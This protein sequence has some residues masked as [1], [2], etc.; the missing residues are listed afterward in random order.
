M[1]RKSIVVQ[2]LVLAMLAALYFMNAGLAVAG[3]NTE[4]LCHV[5]D[6]DPHTILVN[7]N[8]LNAHL[9]HG[10]TVGTCG[11][12]PPVCGPGITACGTTCHDLSTDEG[13]C[14]ACGFACPEGN[15]CLDGTCDGVCEVLCEDA[16]GDGVLAASCGGI[17]CD[18]SD[19]LVYPGAPEL[20]DMV[21]NDCSGVYYDWPEE[22]CGDYIDNDCNLTIDDKDRDGDG[23]V[24]VL[25]GA[26]HHDA[27]DC[28]DNNPFIYTGAEEICNGFDDDCNGRVDDNCR[29]IPP[30]P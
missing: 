10:D 7:E 3:S 26:V 15:L 16:D 30:I 5:G 4:A 24:D 8:A 28:D 23:N 18:D 14:G 22:I 2:T 12:E 19:P 9:A 17:D 25:C 1:S 6:G 13:N 29:Y 11:S 20:C 21:D 27:T